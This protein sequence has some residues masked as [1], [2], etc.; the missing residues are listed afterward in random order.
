MLCT[1]DSCNVR[2]VIRRLDERK[3][4]ELLESFLADILFWEKPTDLWAKPESTRRRKRRKAG[5]AIS[6]DTGHS[7]NSEGSDDAIK[8]S[9]KSLWRTSIDPKTGRTYYYH[10]KTRIPQWDKPSELKLFEKEQKEEKRKQATQ[11]FREM[12]QNILESMRKGELIPGI[13]VVDTKE[14]GPPLEPEVQSSQGHVRTISTMDGS[15]FFADLGDHR[16]DVKATKK[17]GRHEKKLKATP[18]HQPL[19]K[20]LKKG[21]PP[22]PINSSRTKM[23]PVELPTV[24]Q[25]RIA[26]RISRLPQQ[27]ADSKRDGEQLLD[28]PLQSECDLTDLGLPT[29]TPQSSHTRRNTGGTIFLQS[30]MTK[31]DIQATIKCVCGVYRAHILQGTER[32]SMGRNRDNKSAADIYIFLDDH[33]PHR[34]MKPS[35]NVPSLHDVLAFY[36]EFYRKSKMEHDSIIMSLIYVERLVKATNGALNP[37]PENW[38]SVLFACMVLASKVWDDLSMWNV[39]FSNVSTNTAGLLSF[40]LRR[41]NELELSLL[42]HLSFDVRVG[43]S[44][45]AKYYFLIRTMLIRGGLVHENEGPLRKQEAFQKLETLTKNYQDTQLRSLGGTER[46]SKSMDGNFWSFLAST[47]GKTGPVFSDS[48]CLEQIV[49]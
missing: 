27:Q 13:P 37:M 33:G 46:R 2:R 28:A 24:E 38:K 36:E 40:S 18:S 41:I 14:Q 48:V 1:V 16:N 44:E 7:R 45:Y 12:E 10:S 47:K 5:N 21:R 6:S 11:F 32:K 34:K 3:H 30:T 4:S 15:L 9:V 43:A 39:D 23:D 29:S 49:G 35:R 26:N 19:P 22:L 31:P 25:R 8:P 42:K 20:N 17:Q